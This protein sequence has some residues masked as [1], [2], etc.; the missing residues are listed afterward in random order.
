MALWLRT[1]GLAALTLGVWFGVWP[2]I[3][4]G[5]HLLPPA[6]ITTDSAVYCRKLAGRVDILAHGAPT[7]IIPAEALRL[8]TQGQSLCAAGRVRD[9]LICLRRAVLLLRHPGSRAVA[10]IGTAPKGTSSGPP[11]AGPVSVRR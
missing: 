8:R 3:M 1:I 2:A 10:P 5:G 11:S 4:P 6:R 7:E 9:G